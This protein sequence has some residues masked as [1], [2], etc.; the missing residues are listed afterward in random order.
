MKRLCERASCVLL[1]VS[2]AIAGPSGSA[3][4]ADLFTHRAVYDLALSGEP[5]GD[6]ETVDGR[7]VVEMTREACDA[8]QLEYRFVARF[9]GNQELIVVDQRIELEEALDGARLAF[10]NVSTVDGLADQASVGEAVTGEGMTRVAYD[11]PDDKT[12]EIPAASFPIGHTRN[13]I[14]AAK[15]GAFVYEAEIFDGDP[16]AERQTRSTSIISDVSADPGDAGGAADP[17]EARAEDGADASPET[18]G[19]APP[20][21][22]AAELAGLERWRVSESYYDRDGTPDGGPDFSTSYTLYEN[23]VS[24][25][26]TLNFEGYSLTGSMTEFTALQAPDCGPPAVE[27]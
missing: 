15:Q 22:G 6:F 25:Q 18:S 3:L 20:K 21:P 19:T 26:L 2:T 1:G 7:I 23:G 5:S 12:V 13:L 24:D 16:E 17:G 27:N 14:D 10:S 4:S 8:Y 11:K 9:V